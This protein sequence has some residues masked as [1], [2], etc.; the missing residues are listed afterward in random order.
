MLFS[1]IIEIEESRLPPL[2]TGHRNCVR[3]EDLVNFTYP[4]VRF[5]DQ[6]SKPDTII[7]LAY[8][9]KTFVVPKTVGYVKNDFDSFFD[10]CGYEILFA[11]V[12]CESVYFVN[13]FCS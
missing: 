10:L 8:V 5:P 7:F 11:N 1:Q 12:C 2:S 4:W 6:V 9:I 3:G 13:P